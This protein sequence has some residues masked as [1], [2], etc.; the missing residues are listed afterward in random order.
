M[1]MQA[2]IAFLAVVCFCIV[3]GVPKK[4]VVLAGLTGAIGWIIYLIFVKFELSTIIASLISALCV[5]IISAIISKLI[6]AEISI[7]FIPG[8]LPI[9]PGVAMYR[10]VYYVL[11]NDVMMVKKY[12]YEAILIAGAIALAIF[13]VESIKKMSYKKK[14]YLKW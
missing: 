14:G 5:A 11:A 2:I 8:I 12:F 4:F 1:I 6:K 13:A 3:L 7:F 9:V 10:I